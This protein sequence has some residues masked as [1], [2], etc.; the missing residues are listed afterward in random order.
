MNQARSWK[1][2]FGLT[3]EEYAKLYEFQGG[4]CAICQVATGQARA[5]AVDHDHSCCPGPTSCGE[6]VRG[7]CC[8]V[9]N[10]II[11]GR[12]GPQAFRRALQYLVSPPAQQMRAGAVTWLSIG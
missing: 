11:L 1:N 9:C 3:G 10:Q 6:C 12:Y 2:R 4:K 8:S 5:L 7:L